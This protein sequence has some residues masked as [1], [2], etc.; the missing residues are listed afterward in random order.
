MFDGW[1]QGIF[2]RIVDD[3]DPDNFDADLGFTAKF[4]SNAGNA[5]PGESETKFNDFYFGIVDPAPIV[6]LA[7]CNIGSFSEPTVDCV[8]SAPGDANGSEF[9]DFS[10]GTPDSGAFGSGLP[11]F[12]INTPPPKDGVSPGDDD[13]LELSGRGEILEF[14]FLG[15]KLNDFQG[16]GETG[17][18]GMCT[19]AQGFTPAGP[20]ADGDANRTSSMICGGNPPGVIITGDPDPVPGPLPILGLGAMF[21]YA[22]KLRQRI[23]ISR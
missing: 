2:Q 19:H 20:D 22:R 9:Y 7:S 17:E 6:T 5:P 8:P 11:G 10:F 23:K 12:R 16:F 21:A 4:T 13:G 14:T 3:A 18:F 15:I 1:A